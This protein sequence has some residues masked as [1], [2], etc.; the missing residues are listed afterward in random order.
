MSTRGGVDGGYAAAL[1]ASGE[2]IVVTDEDGKILD[3]N[4]AAEA[5]CGRALADARGRPRA[6][7]LRLVD[8][9][10]GEPLVIEP[11]GERA[12]A[13]PD[14]ALLARAVGDRVPVAGAATALPRGALLA[15]RDLTERRKLLERLAIADR[16]GSVGM[17]A[18]SLGHEMGNP[19]SYVAANLDFAMQELEAAGDAPPPVIE[20]LREAR[21]GAERAVRA[22]RQLRAWSR[23]EKEPR[24]VLDL[25]PLLE[26]AAALAWPDIR[27]RARLTKE[28]RLAPP[29]LADE[30]LLSQVFVILLAN[31]AQAIPE[32]RPEQH[33]IRV[34]TTHDAAGAA[35]VEVRDTGNGIARA[36]LPRVF[37]PF[38]TTR[39]PDDHSGLGLSIAQAVVSALGGRVEVESAIGAGS[40]FRVTLPAA[41]A[42]GSGP[43]VVLPRPAA[44]AA[45][46]RLA[47]VLIVDDEPLICGAVQRALS[48]DYQVT[49]F[50]SARAALDHLATGHAY[51]AVLLDLMMPDMTG[52]ELY[53]EIRR[54]MPELLPRVVFL[55]GGAFTPRASQ[56]LRE[57]TQRR[58]EKPFDTRA[59]QAVL[60]DVVS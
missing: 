48:G 47:R 54:A 9:V 49:A 40:T 53:G 20:A 15:L 2:A 34:V 19:L 8:E 50:T 36:D 44:P 35:V 14:G 51:D 5:L 58:L 38:Y 27:H 16:M 23:A 45:P 1:R 28:Y 22:V 31:A 21:V 55:T 17:L 12:T 46:R 6:E 59:L 3:M 11:L 60:A 32:G 13:I 33:E 7:V 39:S 24:R 37:E 4:P 26:R 57:V 43:A 56:F 42:E 10:T 29:V 18:A 25:R 30:A 41:I 52:M